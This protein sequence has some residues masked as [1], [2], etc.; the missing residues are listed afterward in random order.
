MY[1]TIVRDQ[2]AQFKEIGFNLNKIKPI[3]VKIDKYFSWFDQ[4]GQWKHNF[5]APPPSPAS[6]PLSVHRLFW[7]LKAWAQSPVG[8]CWS[9]D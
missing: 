9:F 4:T 2:I 6:S 8:V 7:S 1:V 5:R 3:K